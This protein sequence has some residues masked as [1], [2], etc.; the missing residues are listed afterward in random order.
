MRLVSFAAAVGLVLLVAV[1][2]FAENLQQD[3]PIAWNDSTHQ[4]TEE[5]CADANLQPGQV[6][7]HFVGHFSTDSA[8]MSATFSDSSFDVTNQPPDRVLDHYELQ[9]NIITTETSLLSASVTPDTDNGG[10]N[11]SHICANPSVDV[12]E[13]PFSALLVLSS[14]VTLLGF[15][16][17]RMRQSR[18]AA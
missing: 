5:E 18:M 17:L 3:T 16:G 10:F 11:L 4:G 12:P 15:A 6:L 14:A 2:A 8:V 1:P 7:W 13:A 9:W